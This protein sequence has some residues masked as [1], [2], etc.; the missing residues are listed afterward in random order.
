MPYL[1]LEP[2]TNI[3]VYQDQDCMEDNPTIHALDNDISS[4]SASVMRDHFD[5]AEK[6]ANLWGQAGNLVMCV[7]T[8]NGWKD[9]DNYND[10]TDEPSEP[11][12]ELPTEGDFAVLQ[13]EIHRFEAAFFHGFHFGRACISDGTIPLSNENPCD[14]EEFKEGQEKVRY[15]AYPDPQVI[16]AWER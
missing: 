1:F 3:G 11:P 13:Q 5:T 12:V 14:T 4:Y 9:L 15:L 6:T 7:Q 10:I 8:P 2:I 16:Y